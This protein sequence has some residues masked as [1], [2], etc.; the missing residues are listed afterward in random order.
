MQM[1]GF[2]AAY[3]YYHK[4]QHF[5]SRTPNTLLS[6][7]ADNKSDRYIIILLTIYLFLSIYFGIL[8]L[9]SVVQSLKV[10]KV[11]IFATVDLQY[12]H[13]LYKI[14]HP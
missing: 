7:N 2:R 14:S 12:L 8:Y 4:R 3:K 13:T 1:N 6:Y 9:K 11:K 10:Y 5:L